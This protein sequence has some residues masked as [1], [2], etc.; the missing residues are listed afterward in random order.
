MPNF[1]DKYNNFEFL[2]KID[3]NLLHIP[4]SKYTHLQT[5]KILTKKLSTFFQNLFFVE[6]QKLAKKESCKM[7]K[8]MIL[9]WQNMLIKN[10][11]K[12]PIS[13][14]FSFLKFILISKP[15]SY[16]SELFTSLFNVLRWLVIRM[17][18]MKTVCFSIFLCSI[19]TT[20]YAWFFKHRNQSHSTII[21]NK[22]SR[23]YRSFKNIISYINSFRAPCPNQINERFINILSLTMLAFLQKFIAI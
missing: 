20:V 19:I 6:D 21:I 11:L 18:D 15:F 10:K 9:C 13:I 17:P 22:N 1:G 3:Q 7:L 2:S 16:C 5:C 14:R 23:R 12:L 8:Q 4:H